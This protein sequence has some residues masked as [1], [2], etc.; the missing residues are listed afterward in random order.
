M[1]NREHFIYIYAYNAYHNNMIRAVRTYS[2][3]THDIIIFKDVIKTNIIILCV[4]FTRSLKLHKFYA[5]SLLSPNM[6]HM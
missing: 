4:F 1:S 6:H 3:I 2:Y 5:L